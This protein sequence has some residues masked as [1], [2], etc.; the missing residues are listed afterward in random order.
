MNQGIILGLRGSWSSGI[1]QLIIKDENG[2]VK[3]IPCV[4]TA[5]VC[6]L[7]DCYG[8]VIQSG[9][10]ARQDSFVGKKIFYEYDE[11]GLMLGKFVP[12]CDT[13]HENP[14]TEIVEGKYICETCLE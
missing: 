12:V 8:G 5:T 2:H 10:T 7:D 4:N 1:A 6:A 14:A 11:M 13:C 3:E 9:R